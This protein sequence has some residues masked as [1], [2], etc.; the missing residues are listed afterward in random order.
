MTNTS[1]VYGIDLGTTYSCIAH[2]D[3][4]GKPVVLPNLGNQVVTPS[5]VLI[6][7][8]NI[9]V[10]DDAKNDFVREPGKDLLDRTIDKTRE[11]LQLAAKKNCS[12][13]DEVLLVGGSSMMP[14]VKRRIDTEFGF[15]ARLSDPSQCV[16]KG[17]AIFAL[18][19]A[20]EKSLAQYEHDESGYAE[21]PVH[22]VPLNHKRIVNVTSKTYGTDAIDGLTDA[23]IVYNMIFANTPVPF[24]E[25]KRFC[26]RY[27]NQC[28]VSLG[29]FESDVTD[30]K[31]E[32]KIDM[33]QAR[34]LDQSTLRLPKKMAA[35]H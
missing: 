30:V 9:I 10:G 22:G 27:D 3:E 5:V 31:A 23:K 28:N 13:I 26:L 19:A 2:I 35:R 24:S 15:D 4:H 8:E 1:H 25:S 12:K 21:R 18:D 14:Q 32:R 11:V 33:D 34:L 7:N 6:E 16:A 29:V 20:Y 17:A